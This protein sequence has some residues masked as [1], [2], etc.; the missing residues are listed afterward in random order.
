MSGIEAQY[1]PERQLRLIG[2]PTSWLRRWFGPHTVL[3]ES[4]ADDV[5]SALEA[6]ALWSRYGL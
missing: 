2:A 4:W 5:V 1:A 6:R 3:P